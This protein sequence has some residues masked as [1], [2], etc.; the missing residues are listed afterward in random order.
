MENNAA[1]KAKL[2]M[3]PALQHSYLA[4]MHTVHKAVL[5]AYPS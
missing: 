2:I 1:S 3:I 5:Q 4:L